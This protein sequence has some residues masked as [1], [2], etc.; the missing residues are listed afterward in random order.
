MNYWWDIIVE[1]KDE[2]TI[3][4][5]LV[6]LKILDWTKCK[7]I[8]EVY[9]IDGEEEILEMDTFSVLN[10]EDNHLLNKTK[11]RREKVAQRNQTQ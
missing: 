9:F 11:D 8:P 7:L 1:I 2:E 3:K 4:E 5:H 6:I 10:K